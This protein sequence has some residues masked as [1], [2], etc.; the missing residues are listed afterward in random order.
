MKHIIITIV[1]LMYTILKSANHGIMV[2]SPTIYL[3]WPL[4]WLRNRAKN[5]IEG[6]AGTVND[7]FVEKD[8]KVNATFKDHVKAFDVVN[9]EKWIIILKRY[10]IML[11]KGNSLKTVFRPKNKSKNKS[12]EERPKNKRRSKKRLHLGGNRIWRSK[13]GCFIS[14]TK[15]NIYTEQIIASFGGIRDVCMGGR[16]SEWVILTADLIILG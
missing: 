8:T 6:T 12:E 1:S 11:K 9:R 5:T 13:Q 15:F 14:S 4:P 16:K 10:G 2:S 7:K 3:K